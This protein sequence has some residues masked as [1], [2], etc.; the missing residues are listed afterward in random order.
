M[1][2]FIIIYLLFIYLLFIYLFTTSIIVQFIYLLL[3]VEEH[4]PQNF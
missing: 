2:F 3:F 4:N 1:V